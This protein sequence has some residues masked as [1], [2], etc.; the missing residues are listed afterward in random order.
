MKTTLFKNN[1]LEPYGGQVNRNTVEIFQNFYMLFMLLKRLVCKTWK[2]ST[3]IKMTTVNHTKEEISCLQP[4]V[5]FQSK[6]GRTVFSVQWQ[7]ENW[8]LPQD[9][10]FTHFPWLSFI[11]TMAESNISSMQRK[12]RYE[13]V[14]CSENWEDFVIIQIPQLNMTPVE[15]NYVKLSI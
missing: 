13:W 9:T 5:W 8:W 15:N 2:L 7:E 12:C 4:V 11:W 3:I 14:L 10:T 6:L 1:Q